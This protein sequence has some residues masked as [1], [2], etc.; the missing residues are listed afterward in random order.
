MKGYN[1]LAICYFRPAS[2]WLIIHSHCITFFNCIFFYLLYF[3]HSFKCTFVSVPT[4]RPLL[5]WSE[6]VFYKTTMNRKFSI[7]TLKQHG[8]Y[9]QTIELQYMTACK[10]EFFLSPEVVLIEIMKVKQGNTSL[11]IC[12]HSSVHIYILSLALSFSFHGILQKGLC[13]CKMLST[14][15]TILQ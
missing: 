9:M 14:Y 4:T 15:N 12:C 6:V 8:F 5:R 10:R 2:Y 11:E 7:S 3:L 13:K 1:I